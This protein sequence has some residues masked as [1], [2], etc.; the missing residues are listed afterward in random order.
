MKLAK[1]NRPNATQAQDWM[2][3]NTI[4]KGKKIELD[5]ISLCLKRKLTLAVILILKTDYKIIATFPRTIKQLSEL[6]LLIVCFLNI[7]Y[8]TE[9]WQL[10]TCS[11]FML[12]YPVTEMCPSVNI[13]RT[14][15]DFGK[16]GKH[17]RLMR[18][19][20]KEKSLFIRL[21]WIIFGF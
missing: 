20:E 10:T 15:C 12:Q 1:I 9:N 7:G 17:S 14:L 6:Y 16:F 18:W 5:A 13:F 11:F 19:H 4:I 2:D 21:L 3:L 8:Q